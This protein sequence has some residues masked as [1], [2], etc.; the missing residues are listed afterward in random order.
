M[1]NE[2]ETAV[3]NHEAVEKL[4]VEQETTEP[5]F[6]HGLMVTTASLV[7]DRNGVAWW[8]CPSSRQMFKAK[9]IAV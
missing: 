2:E 1:N 8:V 3:V 7:V 4:T 9:P 6:T 5:F